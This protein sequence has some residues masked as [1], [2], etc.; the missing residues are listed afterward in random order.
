MKEIITH[1]APSAIHVLVGPNSD[2]GLTSKPASF[3][4][5]DQFKVIT[6]VLH[7]IIAEW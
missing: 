7:P 3:D 2:S 5:I 1:R 6:D 4:G